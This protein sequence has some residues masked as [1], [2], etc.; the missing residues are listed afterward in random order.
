[1]RMEQE[2]L[3]ISSVIL[4]RIGLQS[5]QSG[6]GFVHGVLLGIFTSLNFYR[7]HTRNK[8]IPVAIMRSVHSFFATLMVCQGSQSLIDSCN[9]IQEGIL[10][11]VLG[12]EGHTIK[13]VTSPARDKRYALIAYARLASEYCTTM[14]DS[15]L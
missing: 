7:N 14:G 3:K 15:T 6:S 11:M 12:S 4:E 10:W 8:V 9:Q 2:A 13:N 1:M 5:D